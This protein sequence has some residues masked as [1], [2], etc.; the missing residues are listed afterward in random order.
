MKRLLWLL[1]LASCAQAQNQF[2]VS[3]TGSDSNPGTQ[4]LPWATIAHANN[5]FTLGV[6]SGLCTPTGKTWYFS[7]T[8]AVC[9]H[10]LPGTYNGNPGTMNRGGSSDTNRVSYVS[11]TKWGAIIRATGNSVG[12]INFSADF[13]SFAGFDISS[14]TGTAFQ[15]NLYVITMTSGHNHVVGNRIHD[16][17]LGPCI[18]QGGAALADNS[19]GTGGNN[20]FIGNLIFNIGPLPTPI[21]GGCRTIRGIYLAAPNDIVQNNIVYNNSESGIA[22]THQSTH[23][24][25]TN[26]TV[27]NNGGFG[28]GGNPWYITC[29]TGTGTG[30][31]TACNQASGGPWPPAPEPSNNGLG[32][33]TT[34]NH[35][36]QSVDDGN[37]KSGL[38]DCITAAEDAGSTNT[39]T[40]IT[41][42]LCVN[43]AAANGK[44]SSSFTP[45]C[46]ILLG[47]QGGDVTG[48][49]VSNNFVYNPQTGNPT[50]AG[51]TNCSALAPVSQ[52]GAG[53][54][55]T[56]NTLVN[57][58]TVDPLFVNYQSNGSGDYHLQSTSPAIRAGTTNFASGTS[59]SIPAIDFDGNPQTSPPTIGAYSTTSGIPAA[60]A[61]VTATVN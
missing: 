61:N 10:V 31:S 54:C 24:V 34:T 1:V 50:V 59:G 32:G 26:N 47:R 8:A 53:T 51:G 38:G 43:N 12:V 44:N 46:G 40:T 15:Q 33:G 6:A 57:T 13:I 17:A 22:A 39:G 16:L 19:G 52:C 30:F 4:A 20:Q 48:A 55:N 56:G 28:T 9:I 27:F 49:L 25:L 21:Q 58:F 11:D 7:E 5:A 41:N 2:Y 60:P 45:I 18:N 36:C 35:C 23:T 3:P 14:A 29:H 37:V 42:N